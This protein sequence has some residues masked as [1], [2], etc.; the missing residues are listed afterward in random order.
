[1]RQLDCGVSAWRSL[2]LSPS[3]AKQL[4]SFKVPK[5]EIVFDVIYCIPN[6]E[7]SKSNQSTRSQGLER[8]RAG[9]LSGDG[10]C[11]AT[12]ALPGEV[13]VLPTDGIGPSAKVGQPGS[14][15]GA[16]QSA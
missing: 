6:K 12:N 8:I 13:A 11:C 2:G 3:L 14:Q 16:R 5:L 10:R 15:A 1:M 4:R 7:L 9:R